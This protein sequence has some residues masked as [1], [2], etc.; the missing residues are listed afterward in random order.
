MSNLLEQLDRLPDNVVI[1][2]VI[3]L[4]LLV[5]LLTLLYGRQ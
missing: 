5:V 1:G 3:L 4:A 2:F